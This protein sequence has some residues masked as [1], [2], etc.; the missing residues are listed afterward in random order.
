MSTPESGLNKT[1]QGEW[2]EVMKGIRA[3]GHSFNSC[4]SA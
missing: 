2:R 4:Y 3:G 1:E